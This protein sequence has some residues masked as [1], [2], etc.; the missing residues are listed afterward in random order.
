MERMESDA[1]GTA[2]IQVTGFRKNYGSYAAVKGISFS[3]F[4]GEIFGLVGPNGAGKTTT[5]ECLE[6]LRH[7]DG[8]AIR[9]LGLDP[10]ESRR[11]LHPRIGVQL[12]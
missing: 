9:V 1:G 11:K 5:I 2:V 6:G 3:V 8:G 10:W 4:R 7:P 12:Q